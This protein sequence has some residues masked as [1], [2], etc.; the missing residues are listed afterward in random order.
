MQ[1]KIE[2]K[3]DFP[4]N[5]DE[6]NGK[7]DDIEQVKYLSQKYNALKRRLQRLLLDRKP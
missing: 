4:V 6:I 5:G 2:T 7:M 1:E 3:T